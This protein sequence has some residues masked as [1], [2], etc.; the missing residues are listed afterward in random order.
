VLVVAAE[1]ELPIQTVTFLVV[2]LVVVALTLSM[3]MRHLILAL[4][5]Q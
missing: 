1:V 4:L 3:C 5:Y 2:A